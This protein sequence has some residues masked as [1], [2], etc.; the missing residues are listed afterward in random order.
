MTN[1]PDEIEHIAGNPWMPDHTRDALLAAA[2][3]I[4]SNTTA[5]QLLALYDIRAIVDPDKPER[6]MRDELVERVRRDYET[7]RKLPVTEDGVTVVPDLYPVILWSACGEPGHLHLDPQV[8]WI[9]WPMDRIAAIE[10]G[11]EYRQPPTDRMVWPKTVAD[12]YS[13]EDAARAAAEAAREAK[14]GGKDSA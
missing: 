2:E 12:C 14:R 8:G 4:R 5:G 7:L 6:M 11:Q 10:S 3:F 9:V 1:L 13:S